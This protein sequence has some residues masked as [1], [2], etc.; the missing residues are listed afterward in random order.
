M[1]LLFKKLKTNKKIIKFNVILG[2]NPK[3]LVLA[4][5]CGFWA[6]LCFAVNADIKNK[7]TKNKNGS[8]HKK[9]QSVCF[10]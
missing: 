5:A 2:V 9:Y 10:L 4:K 3:P 1:R 7:N 6:K 8:V